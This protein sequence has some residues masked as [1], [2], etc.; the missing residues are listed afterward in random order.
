MF[1][2]QLGAFSRLIPTDFFG[3]KDV[4]MIPGKDGLYKY[5]TGEFLNYEDATLHKQQ[6]ISKGFDDAFVVVYKGGMRVT[7]L[8]AGVYPDSVETDFT[9]A[10]DLITDQKEHAKEDSTN[11]KDILTDQQGITKIVFK[12]QIFAS[13]DAIYMAPANFKGLENVEEYIDEGL[14]KYTSGTAE[15]FEYSRDVLLNQMKKLGYQDAFVVAFING[16]RTTLLKAHGL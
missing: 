1:R 2:V 16:K 3:I 11:T 5:V 14:Y 8:D 9:N 10:N 15:D 6:M 12:I 4:V 7:L 13:Q